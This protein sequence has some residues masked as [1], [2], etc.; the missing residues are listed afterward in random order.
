MGKQRYKAKVT[1][2]KAGE[3]LT[4]EVTAI[5]KC[6]VVVKVPAGGAVSLEKSTPG[7]QVSGDVP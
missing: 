5:R 6:V 1:K 4:V 2:L 3:R 7:L